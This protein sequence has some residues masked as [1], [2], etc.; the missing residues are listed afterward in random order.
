VAGL[1]GSW[2]L[3]GASIREPLTTAKVPILKESKGLSLQSK[4]AG[5]SGEPPKIQQIERLEGKRRRKPEAAPKYLTESELE[6]LL[7]VIKDPRDRAMFTVAY[8]R[9]LRASEVGMLQMSDY[10]VI[11]GRPPIAKLSVHR[12][13]GSRSGEYRLQAPEEAAMRTWI[14]KRGVGPGPLFCSRNHRPISRRRLDELMK[15]YAAIAG[16][17]ADKRHMHALKHSCC[18]H[19][20]AELGDVMAVQDWVGHA[21]LRSTLGYTKFTKRDQAADQVAKKLG[22]KRKI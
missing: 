17:P 22:A 3:V 15:R 14:R 16:I 13:K 5:N 21:D 18:T 6:A 12:L 20:L 19:R 2:L 10:S 11:D 1:E 4:S 8:W 7:K 9:G